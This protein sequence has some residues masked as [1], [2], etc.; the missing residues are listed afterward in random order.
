MATDWV[1]GSEQPE[2][3]LYHKM[4]GCERSPLAAE[5]YRS[6]GLLL[7]EIRVPETVHAGS[8]LRPANL[9]APAIMM[10]L[11][12]TR[13]QA[14]DFL[15]PTYVCAKMFVI[16]QTQVPLD[17]GVSVFILNHF[18]TEQYVL[19]IMYIYTSRERDKTLH[20]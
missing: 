15:Q 14:V 17:I 7:G 6:S 13:G 8:R 2:H 11:F 4:P 3:L 18:I 19:T 5:Q 16:I 12:P 1:A 20:K 10:P 9:K